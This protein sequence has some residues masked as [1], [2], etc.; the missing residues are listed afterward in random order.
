M[1]SAKEPVHGEGARIAS[2]VPFG[3]HETKPRHFSSMLRI[4]WENRDNLPYA[5][6]VLSRGTC[7]GCALGTIGL[8]DWTLG[9][10][11]TH[12]CMVRLELLRLNTMG[13]IPDFEERLADVAALQRLDSRALRELGRLP[14]PMRRRAGDK[15]FS[16]ISWEELFAEAGARVRQVV[17]ADPDRFALWLTSRGVTNETYYVGQKLARFLGTNNVDNSARLC[18]APS[19]AGLKDTIGVAATTCSYA[20]WFDAELIVFI[21]SNPANDQPVSMKYLL[22]AKKRGARVVTLNTYREPGMERYW[23]PSNAG[24]AVFGTRFTDDFFLVHTGGDL[25]LLNAVAKLLLERDGVNEGF[26]AEHTVGVDALRAALA[27]QDLERLVQLSG[28]SREE[29]ERLA[30]LVAG[31]ERGVLVWSMGVTQHAHGA[32][33]VRAIANLGLLRG[34]VG[35]KGCGLMPIRGHSGVQGGAEM[36]AYATAFPGGKPIDEAHAEELSAR[37]GF[38]VPS[39][40]GLAT[41]QMIDAA[42]AG[43]LDAFYV[44]GGNFLETLPQPRRVAAALAQV[45]V[46]LHQDIVLTSQMLVPPREVA[47]LLPARTRYEQRDGGTETTTERRVILSPHIPGHDVGEALSEWELLMRLGIAAFPER[48]HLLRFHDGAAIRSEIG[49]TIPTYAKIAELSEPGDQFQWGG[50]HLCAEGRFPT[51]DGKG[52]FRPVTPPELTI[53]DD[54]LRLSTRRGK[55]FNSMVQAE[56]DPITGARRL[57]VFFAPEDA[58]RLQ[59]VA[60]D[61]VVLES[62]HGQ[63]TGKVALARI[64]PGNIQGHWPEVNGLLPRDRL[65]PFSGVPDYNAVVR[66][67]RG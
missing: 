35:K 38:S 2:L 25:A 20:D 52:H 63:F 58:A 32:D 57:D 40:R 26:V 66:V 4:V 46:R 41:T 65:D 48:G 23:V 27:Q 30:T 6:K 64:R 8:R 55:Q 29:V 42:E 21:G 10:A 49:R 50:P 16:R 14:F 19:T 37:Y 60:G 61:P 3:V 67:R 53:A 9:P 34:W 36:G 54:Q 47:Y 15:G 51:S 22:E 17:E 7:D 18:H 5:W 1:A 59:L 44:V 39:R 33:T 62:E 13:P 45:P 56:V 43:R 28:V 11:E 31:A 12:L 24:S